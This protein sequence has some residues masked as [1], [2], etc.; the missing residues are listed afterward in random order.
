MRR[1]KMMD[2]GKLDRYLTYMQ[3][4]LYTIC[5]IKIVF[6]LFFYEYQ[7]LFMRNMFFT[8]P[9]LIALFVIPVIQK[10]LR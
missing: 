8:V 4:L 7:P 5:F 9:V 3:N 2:S 10:K 6:S 1:R